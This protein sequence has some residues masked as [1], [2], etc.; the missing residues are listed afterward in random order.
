MGRVL[1]FISIQAN[2]IPLHRGRGG[3]CV[4]LQRPAA[5]KPAKQGAFCS[6]CFGQGQAGVASNLLS[7]I[8][9][10]LLESL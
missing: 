9:L 2:R 6:C 8:A 4:F 7:M 1:S 3:T 5:L 10:S